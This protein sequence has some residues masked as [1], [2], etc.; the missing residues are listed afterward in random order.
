MTVV[1][2]GYHF[3]DWAGSHV[4]VPVPR[5]AEARDDWKPIELRRLDPTPTDKSDLRPCHE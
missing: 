1:T 3:A 4:A 2:A 5:G